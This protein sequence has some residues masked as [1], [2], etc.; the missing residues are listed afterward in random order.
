MKSLLEVA[1]GYAAI[2]FDVWGV[3]LEGYGLYEGVADKINE[4]GKNKDIFVLSNAPRPAAVTARGLQSMGLNFKA[5]N[6]MTSG[7]LTRRI[8]HKELETNPGI[9]YLHIGPNKSIDIDLG[10]EHVMTE[11]IDEAH[12]VLMTMG[13]IGDKIIEEELELLEPYI[14]IFTKAQEKGLHA[15]C[16]NPD[17]KLVKGKVFN[18]CAGFFA[19]HYETMGGKVIYVG[20][21]HYEIFE[22]IFEMIGVEDKSKILMVGDTLDTDIIGA[23]NFGVKSA[24]VNTGNTAGK[25]LASG[26]IVSEETLNEFCQSQGIVPDH[27]VKI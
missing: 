10:L 17:T 24:L 8:I 13:H 5:E 20:K 26:K 25:V 21:P 27:Y 14:E 16:A 1:E 18:Y 15:I 6:V 4:I 23:R 12:K 22:A 2:I 11:N 9:K 7:E 3:M 19:S